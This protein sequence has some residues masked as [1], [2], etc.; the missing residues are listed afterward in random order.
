MS[1]LPWDLRTN[2]VAG[3]LCDLTQRRSGE[4]WRFDVKK[5]KSAVYRICREEKKKK[6]ICWIERDANFTCRKVTKCRVRSDRICR[7]R[8]RCQP[9]SWQEAHRVCSL[10][11]QLHHLLHRSESMTDVCKRLRH[12]LDICT[13]SRCLRCH[14]TRWTW[15]F[16]Y[17]QQAQLII[18][19]TVC[20]AHTADCLLALRQSWLMERTSGRAQARRGLERP[21]IPGGS[22][23]RAVKLLG[24]KRQWWRGRLIR[25]LSGLSPLGAIF[26]CQTGKRP[27]GKNPGACT[28][29][30]TTEQPQVSLEEESQAMRGSGKS[31]WR[32]QGW[33]YGWVDGW[34]DLSLSFNA[35]WLCIS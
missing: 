14:C 7:K 8:P 23:D 17:K 34:V 11:S 31:Q 30:L 26:P 16:N 13:W 21:E 9:M 33:M 19:R 2:P 35:Q 25:M 29:H 27:L 6:T 32:E 22:W 10:V 15:T 18:S 4:M 12:D 5:A 1:W 24:V 3:Q 28:S 20:F